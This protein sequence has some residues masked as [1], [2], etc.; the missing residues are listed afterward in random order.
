MDA[1]INPPEPPAPLLRAR[2]A[3][4]DAIHKAMRSCSTP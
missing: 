4:V 2:R 3:G 1:Q